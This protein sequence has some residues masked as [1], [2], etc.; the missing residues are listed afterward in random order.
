VSV[1]EFG[2]DP[3]LAGIID[4]MHVS[5]F[6]ALGKLMDPATGKTHRN[7]DAARFY[8][9]TLEMIEKKTAG[10]LTDAER[11]HLASVLDT[12]RLNYL[13]EMK[14]SATPEGEHGANENAP[15]SE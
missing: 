7:L 10:N 1:T 8:I 4:L 15:P 6:T 5:A 3:H 14:K 11:K 9:D 13:D 2:V 12:L